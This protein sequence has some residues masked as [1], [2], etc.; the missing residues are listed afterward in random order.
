MKKVMIFTLIVSIAIGFSHMH[1]MEKT[2][3]EEV[4]GILDRSDKPQEIQASDKPQ[5]QSL[6]DKM[7]LPIPQGKWV[8]LGLAIGAGAGLAVGAFFGVNKLV[9]TV[10]EQKLAESLALN[11]TAQDKEWF[12]RLMALVAQLALKVPD[13]ERTWE[14]QGAFIKQDPYKLLVED[15]LVN[16]LSAEQKIE[17]K[18]IL[19]AYRNDAIREKLKQTLRA[20]QP[21]LLAV[22]IKEAHSIL[23]LPYSTLLDATQ[24]SVLK[25]FFENLD[26]DATLEVFLNEEKKDKK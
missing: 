23:E 16:A 10:K 14:L 20:D 2:K 3:E 7:A 11:A 12:A 24:K 15:S 22:S 19:K 9:T 5:D 18:E 17:M 8:S 13:F 21:D 1:G 26:A 6:L 4:V 25:D